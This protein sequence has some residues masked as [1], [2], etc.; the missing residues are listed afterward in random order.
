MAAVCYAPSTH[1]ELSDLEVS[2]D[3]PLLRLHEDSSVQC[4]VC[5]ELHPNPLENRSNSLYISFMF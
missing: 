3:I 4:L 1:H 2:I 5:V